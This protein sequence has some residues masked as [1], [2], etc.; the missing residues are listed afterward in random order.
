MVYSV[1]FDLRSPNKDTRVKSFFT[2][3]LNLIKTYQIWYIHTCNY[4]ES[5]YLLFAVWMSFSFSSG[6]LRVLLSQV[7][8]FATSPVSF[9]SNIPGPCPRRP[10]FID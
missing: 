8:D 6:C 9:A 7:S 1:Y 10:Q 2:F 3:L 4:I 5:N